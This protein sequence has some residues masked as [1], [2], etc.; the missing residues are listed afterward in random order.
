MLDEGAALNQHATLHGSVNGSGEGGGRAQLNAAGIIDNQHLQCLLRI[1]GHKPYAQAQQ[2]V[3]R[4]QII[5]ELVRIALNRGF[6]E[7]TGF[8]H[9]H[10]AADH[11]LVAYLAG[12]HVDVA[13]LHDGAGENLVSF[14]LFCRDKLAGNGTLIHHGTAEN[15]HAVHG[16]LLAGMH[17]NRIANGYLPDGGL[18]Q[19]TVVCNLPHVSVISGKHLFDGRTGALDGVG[20]HQLCQVGQSQN[21]QCRV[22][23]A[24]HQ[25]G[26][27]G[28]NRQEIGVGSMILFQS[29][30]GTAHHGHGKP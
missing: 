15:H 21:H 4:H 16:N 10:N 25:A 19:L 29:I 13:V 8:H 23:I 12:L 14:V 17:G 9:A 7:L 26:H 24:Q 18:H 28:S 30:P 2:E 20:G 6:F 1:L 22:S 27:N 3:Q 11:G 5:R